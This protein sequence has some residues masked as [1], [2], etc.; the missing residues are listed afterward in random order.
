MLFPQSFYCTEEAFTV[1]K[2]FLLHCCSSKVFT[3][4]A[5]PLYRPVH[6]G[7]VFVPHHELDPGLG[8]EGEGGGGEGEK[9]VGGAERVVG[10]KVGGEQGELRGAAGRDGGGGGADEEAVGGVG[11]RT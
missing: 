4:F 6:A 10:E 2:M 11:G 8:E 9:G 7:G 3:A 1:S 5:V